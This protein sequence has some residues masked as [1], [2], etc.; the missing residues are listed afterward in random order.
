M[1]DLTKFLEEYSGNSSQENVVE[2]LVLSV[3]IALQKAMTANCV[4]QKELAS[5]LGVSAA[6]VSQVLSADASNLTIKT[7]GRIA[8]A[9][10]EDFEF[11]TREQAKRAFAKEPRPT[12]QKLE[13]LDRRSHKDVWHD[14][15]ANINEFPG[16]KVA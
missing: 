3:Q 4:S 6:R 14:H 8:H 11:V 16:L 10:G 12:F 15:T 2:A 7:I 5:R 9:L 13:R 1:V